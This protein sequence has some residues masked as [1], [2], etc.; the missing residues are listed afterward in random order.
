[1]LYRLLSCRCMLKLDP[2][3][4]KL[5]ACVLY[6]SPLRG[7][8]EQAALPYPSLFLL[9]WYAPPYL[10]VHVGLPCLVAPATV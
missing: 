5:T 4:V 8:A 7:R 2:W 10:Q 9:A 1:L 3:V 6:L